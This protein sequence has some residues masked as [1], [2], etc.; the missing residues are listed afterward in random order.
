M[1]MK[2]Q[3]FLNVLTNYNVNIFLYN[4]ECNFNYSNSYI[5][6]F[7]QIYIYKNNKLM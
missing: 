6:F 5:S 1:K 7:T 3:I 4:L 2:R